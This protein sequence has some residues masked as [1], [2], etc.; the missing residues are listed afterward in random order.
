MKKI[1]AKSLLTP[2]A[3]CLRSLRDSAPQMTVAAALICAEAN[4]V[5]DVRNAQ[6]EPF[7][8]W[9]NKTPLEHSSPLGF[10]I[11]ACRTGDKA[12]IREQAKSNAHKELRELYDTLCNVENVMILDSQG[13]TTDQLIAYATTE[14]F[15]A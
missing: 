12:Y 3:E 13:M 10:F 14:I 7:G 15:Y 1:T 5:A 6:G 8:G 11:K 2:Y 4:H 9:K